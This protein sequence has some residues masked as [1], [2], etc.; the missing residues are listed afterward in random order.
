MG[1]ALDKAAAK[2]TPAALAE[3]NEGRKAGNPETSSFFIIFARYFNTHYEKT[4][5]MKQKL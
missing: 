1:A 5:S 2:T 3:R 4:T